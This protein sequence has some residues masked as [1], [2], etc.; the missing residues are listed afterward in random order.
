MSA[1]AGDPAWPDVAARSRVLW[2]LVL[3]LATSE[4]PDLGALRGRGLSHGAA[5]RSLARQVKRRTPRPGPPAGASP[6]EGTQDPPIA[7]EERR[8]EP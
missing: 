2:P 4:H 7:A 1:P 3:W 8:K 6:D 5:L